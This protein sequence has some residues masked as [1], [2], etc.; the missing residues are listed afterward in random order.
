MSLRNNDSQAFG[1]IYNRNY[2]DVYRYLLVLVKV[3]EI[4]EDITHEV[5]LKVWEL[6]NRLTIERSRKSY[7]LRA[8]HNKA[9]DT[10]RKTATETTLMKQLLHYYKEAAVTENFSEAVQQQYDALVEEALN[11]LTPQRKKIYEMSKK[12]K[13]SYE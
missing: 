10:M 4:A 5:F 7:L 9:I 13:K 6:R 12:E 1:A 2:R 8:D 3:S 11:S